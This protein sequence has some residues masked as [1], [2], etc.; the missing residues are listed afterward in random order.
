[1]ATDVRIIFKASVISGSRLVV[2]GGFGI[3]RQQTGRRV[4]LDGLEVR[5]T[6]KHLTVEVGPTH[7]HL[8]VEVGTTHKHLTVVV[9]PT[10]KHFF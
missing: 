3:P 7:K 10:H 5:L 2:Y 4:D 9:G 8:T 6:H 1:M